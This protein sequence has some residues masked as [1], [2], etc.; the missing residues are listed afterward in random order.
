VLLNQRGRKERKGMK[1][2]LN[3]EDVR[4]TRPEPQNQLLSKRLRKLNL[5]LDMIQCIVVRR[6]S[7]GRECSMSCSLS[8]NQPLLT[9]RVSCISMPGERMYRRTDTRYRGVLSISSMI[10]RLLSRSQNQRSFDAALRASSLILDRVTQVDDRAIE[11][12]NVLC[13]SGNHSS[14][15]KLEVHS[16]AWHEKMYRATEAR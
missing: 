4:Q 10:Q 1:A 5:L 9:E 11:V 16:H 12:L 13:K 14:R 3:R 7:N 8:S 6:K 2:C 15:S